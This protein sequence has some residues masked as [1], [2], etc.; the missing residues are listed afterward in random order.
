[1][2][3]SEGLLYKQTLES[4][5]SGLE[6]GN[7][8]MLKLKLLIACNPGVNAKSNNLSPCRQLKVLDVHKYVHSYVYLANL[9]RCIQKPVVKEDSMVYRCKQVSVIIYD[10]AAWTE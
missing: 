2:L 7:V 1:M 3:I 8:F 9:R 6:H 10:R 4:M 5:E